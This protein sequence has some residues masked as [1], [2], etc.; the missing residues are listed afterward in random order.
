M[1][2]LKNAQLIS[3]I[4]YLFT[5][6]VFMLITIQGVGT[7]EQN[8][9]GWHSAMFF[10]SIIP[11]MT[12]LISF[13]LAVRARPL[14]WMYFMIFGAWGAILPNAIF[15]G[16]FQG[17]TIYFAAVPSLIGML[18]GLLIRHFKIRK[19]KRAFTLFFY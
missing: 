18:L 1:L 12:F 19:V 11:M 17:F 15:A 9:G 14:F 3:I 16:A 4:C 10:Y 2:K 13:F 6:L 5:F 8:G 7:L